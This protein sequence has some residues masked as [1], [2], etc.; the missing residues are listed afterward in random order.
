MAH[1][2]RLQDGRLDLPSI[3]DRQSVHRPVKG[4]H[5]R[6]QVVTQFS[7]ENL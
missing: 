1:Q 2:R 4:L 5:D 7:S 6:I 3:N